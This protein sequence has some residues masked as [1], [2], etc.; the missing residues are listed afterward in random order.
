MSYSYHSSD[1]TTTDDS[2]STTLNIGLICF[3][4]EILKYL[5]LFNK[6]FEYINPKY[7]NIKS[8]RHYEYILNDYQ[9]VNIN[10]HRIIDFNKL[11]NIY[12]KFDI[13]IFLLDLKDEKSFIDC[14]NII[15]L[16]I[17][18]Y[19]DECKNIYIFG[20]YQ[21]K[22]NNIIKSNETEKIY[23]E[24]CVNYMEKLNKIINLKVIDYEFFQIEI[25]NIE[26][27]SK[28]MDYIVE[29]TVDNQIEQK[30]YEMKGDCYMKYDYSDSKCIIM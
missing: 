29:K 25:N 9:F 8:Q 28:Y 14:S 18:L 1:S 5:Q 11:K 12:K 26:N 3:N 24:Y 30:K 23:K 13:F 2:T 7:L 19:E 22:N 17:E 21:K 20:F 4:S 16:L 15:D 27:F 10:I 6:Y